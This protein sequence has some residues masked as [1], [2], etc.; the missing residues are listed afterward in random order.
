VLSQGGYDLSILLTTLVPVASLREE[1]VE[2][3][4][5]SLLPVRVI[6]EFIENKVSFII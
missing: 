3:T 4:F 5:E 2:W 6:S 1:D